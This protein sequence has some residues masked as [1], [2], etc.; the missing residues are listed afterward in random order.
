MAHPR[1]AHEIFSSVNSHMFKLSCDGMRIMGITLEYIIMFS[2]SEI[3]KCQVSHA[4]GAL[5]R[6][7]IGNIFSLKIPK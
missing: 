3:G 7:L 2:S 1:V 4:G 5:T 6:I